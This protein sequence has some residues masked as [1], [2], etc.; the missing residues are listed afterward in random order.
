MMD[1]VIIWSA[2]ILLSILFIVSGWHK[3]NAPEYYRDLI[4][5]YVPISKPLATIAQTLLGIL[6]IGTGF[7][8]FV[9][10]TRPDAALIAVALLL[11]YL[12]LIAISLIR[13]LDMDCGCSGPVNEQKLSPW[14]LPRNAGLVMMAY[15]LTLTQSHRLLG[16]ADALLI[17]VVCT[18]S[19]CI[20]LSFEQLLVNQNKLILLRK[21]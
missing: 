18:V 17:L 20:Y 8:L 6:E 9:P 14:L 13:G 5:K 15:L 4:Q 11:C 10:V 1:P 21:Q 16:I 2:S 19:L 3:I 12:L 7:L